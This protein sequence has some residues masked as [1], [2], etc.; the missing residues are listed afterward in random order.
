MSSTT[1]GAAEGG[2]SST[3]ENTPPTGIITLGGRTVTIERPTSLKASRALAMLRGISKAGPALWSELAEFRVKY[4]AENYIE[5]DVVQARLRFPPQ[6]VI[7]DNDIVTD[8]AGQPVMIPSPVDSITPEEWADAGG[9]LRRPKS[10]A[11]WEIAVALLDSGVEELETLLY[12]FLALFTIPNAELVEA[13]KLGTVDAVIGEAA[14]WLL[15]DTFADE[16]LELAVVVNE[17]VDH[18]FKRKART[19]GGDRLGKLLA[20]LPKELRQSMTLTPTSSS[21]STDSASETSPESAKQSSST[22]TPRSTDGD[23]TPSSPAPTT[24]SSTSGPSS[25]LTLS[26]SDERTSEPEPDTATDQAA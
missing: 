6:P 12:R 11:G 18:H 24:S 17:T 19:I 23:P 4:E 14:D 22:D 2:A 7:R 20:L 10:P 3:P 8:E 16:L 25:P 1:P 5:L 13:R 21:S 15:D 9:K 26:D